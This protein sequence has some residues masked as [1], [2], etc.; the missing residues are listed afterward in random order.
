MKNVQL[1]AT[2]AVALIC[3]TAPAAEPP[4]ALKDPKDRTS[5]SFGMNT[6][7][8]LKSQGADLDPDLVLKGLKDTLGTNQPLLT[9]QEMQDVLRAWQTEL[10]TKRAELMK[11]QGDKG[12]K[13]GQAFLAENAKKPGVIALPSGLQYKVIASGSGPM[14]TTNDVVQAHYKGNLLDGTEF[15]NSYTRGLPLTAPVI[16]LIPG[17]TEALLKMRVGDRWQLFIPS[18]LA[19]REMGKPPKIPP[20][21]T[22]LFEMELVRIV[23]P[24]EIAKPP[25]PGPPPPKQ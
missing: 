1:W 16:H 5:Y 21:A 6:G 8:W 17:W 23:D 10:R 19:Y 3:E 15:D 12:W 4:S 11:T 20:N 22:L 24:K 7:L 9:M 25:M 2:A 18:N 14:P 13:E